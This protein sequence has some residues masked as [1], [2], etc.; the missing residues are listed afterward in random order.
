[1]SCGRV[2]VK[3]Q[4]SACSLLPPRHGL[5]DGTQVIRIVPEAVGR[6]KSWEIG[7]LKKTIKPSENIQTRINITRV[8]A[9]TLK[10]I[11]HTQ[12]EMMV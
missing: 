1:M 10:T 12:E 3:G 9:Y 7:V 6:P 11:A 5:R 4:A 8:M 2:E